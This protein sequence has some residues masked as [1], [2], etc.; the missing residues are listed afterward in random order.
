MFDEYDARHAYEIFNNV[1]LYY[2]IAISLAFVVLSILAAFAMSKYKR[3]NGFVDYRAILSTELAPGISIV[4][5]AY[6]EEGSIV[7][8]VRSLL[9]VH[10]PEYEIIIVNDGSKDDTLQ[11]LIDAYDLHEVKFA[12]NEQID[13]QKVRGV[14]KS[15]NKAYASVRVVDKENGGKADALNVG[16]NISTMPLIACID[17]D[18]ILAHDALLKMVKPFM[19]S[20]TDRKVIATGGVIR[21]ANSCVIHAGE[22]VKV[23]LPRK[24]KVRVQV[25]EYFRA[26][27]MGRMA[28]AQIDGLLLIS[29]AFGMFD[30]DIAIRAG[31]YDTKTVGEDMEL[32]VRMR[33]LMHKEKTK[34]RVAFIP[35]PLCWTEVPESWSILRKQRNRWA[36]GTIETLWKH[37]GTIL[38]P[39]Y[40]VMGMISMPFWVLF[41][42]LAPL[43]E[44]TGIILYI[45]MAIFGWANWTYYISFLILVYC[46]SIMFTIFSI[47]FEEVSYQQYKNPKYIL[48]LVLTTILEPL[49]YHP[50]VVLASVKGNIDQ[51]LGKKS[52]GEMTRVGFKSVKEPE[53]EDKPET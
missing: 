33:R 4:A 34:Y 42:W 39:R 2:V 25:L 49:L 9:S 46:F 13:T 38:N 26:F 14:Y 19:E 23:K 35:D 21:A 52:W 43:I 40:G 16:L 27:L 22:I 44:L 20:A 18:C 1:I 51:L 32:V 29:G 45:I 48:T 12:I 47:W 3:R 11:K 8:N 15:S 7:E 31:G 30:K 17:V 10:Y 53:K 37:R 28:W 50:I 5:P 24:Y 6:N 41:E 36:R